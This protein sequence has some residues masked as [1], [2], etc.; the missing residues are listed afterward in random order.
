MASSYLTDKMQSPVTLAKK[1][2][3]YNS[4]HG[5]YGS[6]FEAGAKKLGFGFQEQTTDTN[7][8][9]AALKNGQIVVSGQS[10]GLFTGGGHYI[11]LTGMTEDGRIWV[12]DP[13]GNNYRKDKLK[14]GFANGFTQEDVFRCSVSFWIFEPKTVTITST[15]DNRL[16][17][18]YHLVIP[19]GKYKLV[20]LLT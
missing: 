12:N 18:Q 4:E 20:A 19:I 11:L 16:Q 10:V 1:F 6:L 3:S 5:S 14:D 8:V 17:M 7:K 15:T 13:N 2:G 9:I